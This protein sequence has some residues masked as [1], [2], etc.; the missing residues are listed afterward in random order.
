MYDENKWQT[1]IP[2]FRAYRFRGVT[3]DLLSNMMKYLYYIF[4]LCMK[5][6][7]RFKKCFDYSKKLGIVNHV[8]SVHH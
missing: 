8:C 6:V 3:N 4:D 2:G 1:F 7:I 5:Y